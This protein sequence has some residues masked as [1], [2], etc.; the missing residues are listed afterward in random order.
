M[1]DTVD[2]SGPDPRTYRVSSCRCGCGKG[3]ESIVGKQVKE[4]YS[5]SCRKRFS[6]STCDIEPVTTQPVTRSLPDVLVEGQTV[7]GE[8]SS[9]VWTPDSP[10][11][12]CYHDSGIPLPGD[13][14]YVG[15]CVLEDGKWVPRSSMTRSEMLTRYARS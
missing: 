10:T 12:K 15:C 9:G 7:V 14:G 11:S 2:L 8:L 4:F 13:P 3:V 6:R 1:S 5:S